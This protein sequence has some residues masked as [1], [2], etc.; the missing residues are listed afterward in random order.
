VQKPANPD[1]AEIRLREKIEEGPFAFVIH[2]LAPNGL[3]DHWQETVYT[4]WCKNWGT[5]PAVERAEAMVSIYATAGRVSFTHP[6]LLKIAPA[7]G[8][9]LYGTAPWESEASLLRLSIL[10]AFLCEYFNQGIVE[11]LFRG[12]TIIGQSPKAEAV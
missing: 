10:G 4:R 1:A 2:I 5:V 7:P 3:P 9:I 12:R 8:V 11:I 6:D